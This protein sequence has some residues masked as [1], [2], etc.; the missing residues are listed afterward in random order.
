MTTTRWQRKHAA[1]PRRRRISTPRRYLGTHSGP[2]VQLLLPDIRV[3]APDSAR[4]PRP[5]RNQLCRRAGKRRSPVGTPAACTTSTPSVARRRGTVSARP[6]A[7]MRASAKPP[8]T[9]TNGQNADA[10]NPAA[11]CCSPHGARRSVHP[12]ARLPHPRQ[13]QRLAAAVLVA[14]RE[15]HDQ[16]GGG[17]HQVRRSRTRRS[18]DAAA[19]CLRAC[20]LTYE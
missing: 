2:R 16:Q 18:R 17:A 8:P 15:D 11:P 20:L 7:S 13:A 5:Q 6:A 14:V 19:L 10:P 3:T 1:I 9:C 12:S 4:C